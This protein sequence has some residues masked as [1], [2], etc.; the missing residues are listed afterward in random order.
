MPPFNHLTAAIRTSTIEN[1]KSGSRT[2]DDATRKRASCN[3]SSARRDGSSTVQQAA[4]SES[5]MTARAVHTSPQNGKRN[6]GATASKA[7]CAARP[8]LD[9]A[10]CTS[11]RQTHADRAAEAVVVVVV[12]ADV[13]AV[14]HTS[15][16]LN[17]AIELEEAVERVVETKTGGDDVLVVVIATRI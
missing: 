14:A 3:V 1:Q 13:A 5:Q 12:P 9:M 11:V 4:I 8:Y 7:R 15:L 16:V 17:P 6:N 2:I 10:L